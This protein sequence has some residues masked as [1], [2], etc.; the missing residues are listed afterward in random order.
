VGYLQPPTDQADE[1][2]DREERELLEAIAAR[3]GSVVA[4]RE[5]EAREHES[6]ETFR[7]LF[8]ETRAPITLISE[9]RFVAANRATLDMMRCARLE[10]FVGRRPAEVSPEYQPDGRLSADKEAELLAEVMATGSAQFEWQHLRLDGTPFFAEVLLTA[11]TLGGK[12][13]VHVVWRDISDRI[14]AQREVQSYREKLEELVAERT[15]ALERANEALNQSEQRFA[16][17]LEATNDGIWDWDIDRGRLDCNPAYFGMLGYE[18]GQF[19]EDFRS[20]WTALLHPQ[21]RSRALA[22]LMSSLDAGAA[23]FEFRMRA[24]GG[25]Y[26]WIL[27]RGKVVA[28]AEDGRPLRAVGTHTD[29]TARKEL[30]LELREAR[31]RAEAA[32]IAKSTFLANMSHEIRTPMNAI[33]GFTHLMTRDVTDPVQLDRL[34]KIGASARHLLGIINDILDLSKV[35][36]ERLV[37]EEA[38]LNVV[39]LLADVR[40]MMSERAETRGLA[41]LCEHDPRLERMTLVGDHMRL[42]QVL[43]NYV[44]NAIKFTE[45]G[46]VTIVVQIV[47]Q[48]VERVLLRFEVRDTGIG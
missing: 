11:I 12:P 10:D 22:R 47:S 40:S 46:S 19:R 27:S 9:G 3:I 28:R 41:L 45:R 29:L 31:D 43:V 26:R 18:P 7:V 6:E 48:S 1:S 15:A 44:G 20:R 4:R 42:T 34:G 39:A 5:I 25:G 35:E 14:A 33:L 30:E 32:S 36:A 13:H 23:E 24:R 16:F 8:E 37:L 2:F 38:N 17:A 21:D